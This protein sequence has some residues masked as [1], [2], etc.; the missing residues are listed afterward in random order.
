MTCKQENATMLAVRVLSSMK[1]SEITG[2]IQ[3]LDIE[4]ID[5]LMK[6]IYKGFSMGL[7]GQQCACLLAW[8]E[9]VCDARCT[10]S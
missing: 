10:P 7:D 9:K 3:P 5:T 1:T 2:A 4:E 8:H 6:Y